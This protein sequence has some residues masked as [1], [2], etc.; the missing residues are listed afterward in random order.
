MKNLYIPLIVSAALTLACGVMTAP[1]A[2]PAAKVP[3]KPSVIVTSEPVTSTPKLTPCGIVTAGRLNLRAAADYLSPADGAG[4]I[5]GDVVQIVATVG[6]WYEIETS[7]SR[8]GF[9]RAEYVKGCK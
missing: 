1:L 3:I 6:D 4:L 8:R 2:T 5:K 9:A 7:D